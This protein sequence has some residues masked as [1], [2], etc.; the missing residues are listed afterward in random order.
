[1]EDSDPEFTRMEWKSLQ[2]WGAGLDKSPV[3]GR[4]GGGREVRT[5]IDFIGITL[6][7]F[8]LS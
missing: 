4:R 2:Y 5:R 6:V 1:M 3:L 8:G 7:L